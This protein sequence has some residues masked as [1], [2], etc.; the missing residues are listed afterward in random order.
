MTATNP[1]PPSGTHPNAALVR[2]LYLAIQNADPRAIIACYADDAHF[3]DIA[4]QLDG[5]A[6]ILEMWQLVC[7]S[8]PRVTIDFDSI[9]ADDR[10]GNGRW[11]ATYMFGKTD[12][13]P[14][15]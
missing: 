10:T 13:K 7:H 4:F 5:K 9:S 14:G 2:T 3:E 12:T 8:K 6:R 11:M 1:P 15:R